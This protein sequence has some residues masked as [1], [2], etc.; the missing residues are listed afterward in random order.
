M[1]GYF[2]KTLRIASVM[3]VV[4]APFVQAQPLAHVEHMGVQRPQYCS[5]LDAAGAKQL[6]TL[7]NGYLMSAD[8]DPN[9]LAV[10]EQWYNLERTIT[11]AA[12]EESHAPGATEALI[13]ARKMYVEGMLAAK[14]GQQHLENSRIYGNRLQTLC[15][16]TVS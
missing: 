5:M 6:T 15:G 7:G 9:K 16:A 3:N 13:A 2:K 1:N 4:G 10:Q 14:T 11:Q 8:P 12:T